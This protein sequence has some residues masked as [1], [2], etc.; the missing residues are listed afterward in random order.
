[1]HP[2]PAVIGGIPFVKFLLDS[3]HPGLAT[4]YATQTAQLARRL[5]GDGH[6][7]A[8]ADNVSVFG[9]VTSWEGIPVLPHGLVRYNNDLRLGHAAHFFG[10][11]PGLL[12]IIYD[13]WPIDPR[14]VEGL[15]VAVWS[16][17][18]CEPMSLGDRMFYNATRAQ[19]IAMSRYGERQM[20][21]AG[22]QPVYV[23]HGVDTSVFRP[24][25]AAERSAARAQLGV[26]DDQ[27]MILIV[28]MNKGVAPPRKAWDAQLDA[29]ARF[30]ARHPEAVL[31]CH[32]LMDSEQGVDL[33]PLIE[34]LGL[35]DDVL[36]TGQYQQL[37]GLY[38]PK[39][40]AGLMG[41]ADVLSNVSLGEGFGLPALEAQA[42][43]TPVVVGRNSA[44]TELC[45]AGWTVACQKTWNIEDRAWWRQPITAK[46]LAAYEMAWQ[47]AR[48]PLMRQRAREFAAGYDTDEVW[49]RFWKPAIDMLE[50]YAGAVPV[51]P[52][53]RN[54]GAVP[55]PTREADGFRWIQRGMHTG[56]VLA[57]HHEDG[58]APVLEDMLP[59]GGVFLDVGAH[60]GRW[61]LRMARRAAKVIAV[62]AR[63]DTA[64][65][66]RAHLELN[67][68]AN[69]ELLE[70]AAWD[71]E[72]ELRLEDPNRHASAGGS[73][74]VLPDGE[75]ETVSAMPLD[76]LLAG[77]QRLDAVKVDVEGADLHVIRGL[78]GTLARLRPRMVVEDHSIY[79]YYQLDD[80]TALISGLGYQVRRAHVEIAPGI[81]GPYLLCEPEE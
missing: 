26:A 49:A 23:P 52:P 69:V 28:A 30:R 21:K 46:I 18:H 70:V 80:L 57:L 75:G 60:V 29:F 20:I 72:T 8:I 56:D 33:M 76:L 15:A 65:V 34:D 39:Y 41:A 79:G 73:T 25:D 77:E 16:P 44:Q 59:E 36:F 9:Q 74:R 58:L 55:L 68:V 38:P 47:R 32:A 67:S 62:E 54:H 19:P 42:C 24:L 51:R 13:A 64:A 63:P 66:L 78:A 6:T 1:M 45:G 81:T 43:G 50:Q 3:N 10:G 27:F 48:D 12:L 11:D 5:A 22:L 7:V 31:V 61:S 17:V 4:G 37:A 40:V 71:T 14:S 53:K 35:G 2:G